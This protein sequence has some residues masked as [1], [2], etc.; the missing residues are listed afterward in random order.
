MRTKL[1][2]L[3]SPSFGASSFFARLFV[4]AVL[5]KFTQDATLLNFEIEPL[6]SLVNRFV[7]MYAHVNHVWSSEGIRYRIRGE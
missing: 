6:K 1:V 4:V 7:G 3:R 5:F 2:A